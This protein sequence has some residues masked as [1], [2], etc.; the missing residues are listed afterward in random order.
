MTVLR[1]FDICRY[2]EIKGI[3]NKNCSKYAGIPLMAN[4]H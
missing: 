4:L 1:L 2:T 3:K